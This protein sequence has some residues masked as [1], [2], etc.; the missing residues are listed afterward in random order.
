[1]LPSDVRYAGYRAGLLVPHLY[2]RRLYRQRGMFVSVRSLSLKESCVEVRFPP[3]PDF[4]VLRGDQRVDLAPDEQWGTELVEIARTIARGGRV[5]D[6]LAADDRDQVLSILDDVL[7]D[8]QI[9]RGLDLRPFLPFLY[10]AE[11][12][13][14]V[15]ESVRHLLQMIL[16][17][18]TAMNG[19]CRVSASATRLIT[20]DSTPSLKA[21]IPL[22]WVYVYG[23]PRGSPLR[24]ATEPTLK[25]LERAVCGGFSHP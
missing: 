1:M 3:D 20:G 11:R 7:D 12:L 4:R 10:P 2:V 9:G 24:R 6:L 22:M 13:E 16:S 17:L 23:F 8:D 15:R 18:T 19:K 21:A 5:P 14:L 25:A